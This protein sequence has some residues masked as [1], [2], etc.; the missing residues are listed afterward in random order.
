MSREIWVPIKGFEGVYEVS[1]FGRVRSLNYRH[2]GQTKVLSPGDNGWGY[3]QVGLCKNGKGKSYLVHRLVA[4][5]FLPNW[6]DYPEVNHRDEN[7]KNNHVSNLEWCDG[8]YN[9][10]YGTRNQRA[11][12]KMTNGK[13]SKPVLQLTKTRELVREWPSTQ[14]A[15]RNG[16]D[17]SHIA[18]CCRGELKSHKGFVWKYKEVS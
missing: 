11:A 9:T 17:H 14:E 18:A 10:N 8:R 13:L 6:F 15:G 12:E 4:E 2:T 1:S 7:P 5:A 16:F 3:L